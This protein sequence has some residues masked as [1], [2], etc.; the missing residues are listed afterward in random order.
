MP[1]E[2]RYQSA[3]FNVE[4]EPPSE[5]DRWLNEQAARGYV[6]R[7]QTAVPG[8]ATGFLFVTTERVPVAA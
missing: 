7:Q 1:I 5:I 6:L 3:T 4:T 8:R 2:P